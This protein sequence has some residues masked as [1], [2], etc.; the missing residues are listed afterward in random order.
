MG[1]DLLHEAAST[2]TRAKML[3]IGTRTR[4]KMLIIAAHEQ[5]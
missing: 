3:I 1:Y 2:R 5:A 4:A